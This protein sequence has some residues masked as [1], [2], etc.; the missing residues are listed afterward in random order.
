MDTTDFEYTLNI[1]SAETV[2]KLCAVGWTLIQK[3]QDS[4]VLGWKRGKP[5]LF[6][7]NRDFKEAIKDQRDAEEIV[8]LSQRRLKEDGI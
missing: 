8:A 7:N 1:H 3:N 6:R 5:V 4:C 2:K